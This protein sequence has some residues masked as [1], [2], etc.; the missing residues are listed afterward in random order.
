MYVCMYVC[1]YV[2]V[3]ASV[4]VLEYVCFVFI[5]TVN[6]NNTCSGILPI[7]HPKERKQMS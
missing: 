6:K 2:G 3:Y 1:M 5:D 4:C 7:L